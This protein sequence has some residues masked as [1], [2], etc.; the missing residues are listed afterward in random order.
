MSFSIK[1]TEQKHKTFNRNLTCDDSNVKVGENS[2]SN[3]T[4]AKNCISI[5]SNFPASNVDNACFINNIAGVTTDGSATEVVIDFNGQMGTISSSK[6]YKENIKPL[7]NF[8]DIL[9]DLNPVSFNYIS[10]KKKKNTV[11]LIA[12][13]VE[14]IFPDIVIKRGGEIETVQY[15]LLSPLLLNMIINLKKDLDDCEKRLEK[16]EN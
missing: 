15:H 7:G 14:E 9:Y 10:D 16:L 1:N 4:S 3:I 13:E 6:R 2:G 5:G 8:T 11:G 12:E